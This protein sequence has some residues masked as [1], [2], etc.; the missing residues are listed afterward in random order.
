MVNPI[1][2]IKV[3][4]LLLAA[5]ICLLLEQ[6]MMFGSILYFALHGSFRTSE[7]NRFVLGLLVSSFSMAY[8]IGVLFADLSGLAVSSCRH[9]KRSADILNY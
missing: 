1:P 2:F 8:F 6:M 7:K 3:D 5:V 4:V 9:S